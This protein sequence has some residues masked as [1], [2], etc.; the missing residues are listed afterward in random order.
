MINQ[1]IGRKLLLRYDPDHPEVW[2]IPDE[3]I[4]GYEI[5]QK[6]GSHIIHDYSP[7]D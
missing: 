7:S 4:D 3:L 6:I 5:E 1:M 2:F